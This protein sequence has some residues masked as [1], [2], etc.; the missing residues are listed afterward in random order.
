[1]SFAD[2]VSRKGLTC[3]GARAVKDDRYISSLCGSEPQV[4]TNQ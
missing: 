3:L 1:M 4:T 2:A